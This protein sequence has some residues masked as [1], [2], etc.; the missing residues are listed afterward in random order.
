MTARPALSE[1]CG[2]VD[3]VELMAS[4]TGREWMRCAS[5]AGCSRFGS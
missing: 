5:E 2:L 3:T 4:G 1:G